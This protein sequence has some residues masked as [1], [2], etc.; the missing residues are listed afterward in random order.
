MDGDYRSW[1]NFC[2][3]TCHLFAHTFIIPALL[4]VPFDLPSHSLLVGGWVGGV[5]WN[6]MDALCCS[7]C[8]GHRRREHF[9]F[10]SLP[11]PLSPPTSSLSCAIRLTYLLHPSLTVLVHAYTLRVWHGWWLADFS[12]HLVSDGTSWK[13]VEFWLGRRRESEKV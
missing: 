6:P 8:S 3:G 2:R 7:I 5:C 10:L 9:L 1:F 13:P 11:S 4:M 12:A